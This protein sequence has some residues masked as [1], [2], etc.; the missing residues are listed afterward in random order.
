LIYIAYIALMPK[1]W[2]ATIEAHRRAVR[3]AIL[4]TTAALVAEDGLR[5]VT[6]SQI[7]EEA[8]IGRAT[9]YK[10]FPDVETI[11]LAWHERQIAG[12]LDYLA[13]VRDQAGEAGERLEAVL[14]AYALISHESRGHHNT[15][16]AAFLHRDEQVARA[17]RQL[18]DMIRDL[19]T[20]GAETGDL[21]D[22]I[23]P[24]ELASYCLHALTAAS[25]LPS[26]AAVRRLVTVTLAGLRPPR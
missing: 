13:E 22:D 3:D 20:E 21:R 18:R 10:Y 9:L 14:A 24:D 25:S 15:E 16:L 2:N 23:A 19:L 17:Q 11:L 12:H 4:D 8:G 26:E 1:L 6:M 7:A 5:S